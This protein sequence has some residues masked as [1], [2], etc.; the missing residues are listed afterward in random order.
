MANTG[1]NWNGSLK[2]IS[3]KAT[4]LPDSELEQAIGAQIVMRDTLSLRE[5]AKMVNS[6]M[7]VYGIDIGYHGIEE[8]H[9][10]L[11]LVRNSDGYEWLPVDRRL[12][13]YIRVRIPEIICGACEL[14]REGF[15]REIGAL[16]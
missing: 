10:P 7:S 12:A 5:L 9:S 2:G 16:D 6:A 13:Q 4:P 8:E 14:Q 3:V 15:Y 1:G 11:L